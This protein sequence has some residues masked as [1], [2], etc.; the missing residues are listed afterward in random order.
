MSLKMSHCAYDTHY[1][2]VFS[3]KYRKLL[4]AENVVGA[5]VETVAADQAIAEPATLVLRHV[6]QPAHAV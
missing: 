3:V 5:I 2:I 1:H 6:L 4:L